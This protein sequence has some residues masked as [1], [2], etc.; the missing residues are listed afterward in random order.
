MSYTTSTTSTTTTCPTTT[1]TS[2]ASGT[3]TTGQTGQTQLT[4]SKFFDDCKEGM[5]NIFSF[6]ENVF[7]QTVIAIKSLT[8]R[9]PY[10]VLCPQDIHH[11]IF[12]LFISTPK[13]FV[14]L[15]STC[16][17]LLNNSRPLLIR[18]LSDRLDAASIELAQAETRVKTEFAKAFPS[19]AVNVAAADLATHYPD[20]IAAQD[21]YKAKVAEA[22]A[23][24]KAYDAL[25]VNIT[26]TATTNVT[27]ATSGT[28]TTGQTGR[29]EF[30]LS[31]FSDDCQEAI[32]NIFSFSKTIF[33]QTVIAIKSLT[34]RTPHLLLCPKGVYMEI[35]V[36]CISRPKD[37][38]ALSSTCKYLKLNSKPFQIYAHA[39][40]FAS[41]PASSI[42]INSYKR[43]V[44]ELELIFPNL[45]R[46]E[47]EIRL[48]QAIKAKHTGT[49]FAD[50]AAN[51]ADVTSL[52]F[53]VLRVQLRNEL[54][55][56]KIDLELELGALCGPNGYDGTVHAAWLVLDTAQRELAQAETKLTTEFEKAFPGVSVTYTATELAKLNFAAHPDLIAAQDAY[57][58]KVAEAEAA[59]NAF[60]KITARLNTLGQWTSGM[61]TG[62]TVF[63]IQIMAGPGFNAVVYDAACKMSNFYAELAID[64]TAEN[65]ED[66]FEKTP[67]IIG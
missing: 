60:D 47:I 25:L 17:C 39:Y 37:F 21:A 55:I 23:A 8:D 22:E 35:F 30:T 33:G 56:K 65:E 34:D 49:A 61:L 20:L 41:L 14:A 31:E 11:T 51:F 48:R 7:G 63:D 5:S 18:V 46:T 13:D 15:R 9:T 42:T 45:S 38:V 62:G 64:V 57:K 44:A 2:T 27:N 40:A 36:R 10:L 50:L 4:L 66:R 54:D 6:S 59:Q 28:L 29:T 1:V 16:K 58:A 52:E 19:V 3:I 12:A 67:S 53:Q 26:S 32:Y 43:K 24:Q